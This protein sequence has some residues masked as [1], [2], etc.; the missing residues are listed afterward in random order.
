[1]LRPRWLGGLAILIVSA[2][3]VAPAAAQD[4]PGPTPHLTVC[5]ICD[6]DIGGWV[7]GNYS[8]RTDPSGRDQNG[9]ELGRAYLNF[10]GKVGDRIS[11]RVTPDLFQQTT[12]GSDAYY[13]G[14]SLRIKYAYLG[15]TWVKGKEAKDWN[16]EARVGA[17]Q[18]LEI[19][20]EERFWARYLGQVG[21]E[22]NGF[23]SSSDVGVVNVVR[24]PNKLGEL[25]STVQNGP[26]YASR[27]TDR[28]KDFG[29]RLSIT[30]LANR[31]GL[32]ST[33]EFAGWAYTGKVASKNDVGGSG[34]RF[35]GLKRD[36]WGVFAGLRDPNLLLGVDYAERIDQGDNAP[37]AGQAQ[38]VSDSTG[39][40]LSTY[41]LVKPLRLFHVSNL[42]L[43]F[44][45]RDDG[46]TP[47]TNTA[48]KTRYLVVGTT[49]DVGERGQVALDWQE[50]KP[51][52][53]LPAA[54]LNRTWF[55]HYTLLF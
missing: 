6:L 9:F 26:G 20:E 31:K 36:R 16:A 10:R 49:M 15:Y 35:K 2:G 5:K 43:G 18:T 14:W 47:N 12:A 40:L 52:G 11:F 39:R 23:F 38:V 25:Y 42:P 17:A 21:T 27:E 33:L 37:T 28:F 32:L 7:F 1:M 48:P 3:A 19:D 13:K 44:V 54:S 45:L 41:L 55:F 24:L 4:Q 30:P 46:F 34:L 22:R 51:Y 8:Y 29:T 50:S 53:G